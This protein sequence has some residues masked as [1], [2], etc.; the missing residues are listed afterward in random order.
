MSIAVCLV[1]L[2]LGYDAYLRALKEKEG[3]KL[4]GQIVG[5]SVMVLALI[6]VACGVAHKSSCYGSMWGS[7]QGFCP[8]MTKANCVMRPGDMASGGK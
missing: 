1:A 2:A 6:G 8:M 4:L 5:V 7:K 3:L